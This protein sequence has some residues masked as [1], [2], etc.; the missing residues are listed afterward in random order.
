ML[1]PRTPLEGFH[2]SNALHC[3]AEISE[4]KQKTDANASVLFFMEYTG[5]VRKKHKECDVFRMGARAQPA[6]HLFS[7]FS[8]KPKRSLTASTVPSS[9]TARPLK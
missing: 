5:H 3:F 4:R 2:P 9:S 7:T 1:L 6:Y 8:A